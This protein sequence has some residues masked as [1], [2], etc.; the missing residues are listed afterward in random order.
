MD[1]PLS[2]HNNTISLS[3]MFHRRTLSEN[4]IRTG[5][6]QYNTETYV[7]HQVNKVVV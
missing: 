5:K 4:K 7:Y 1:D 2:E 3:R 6:Q